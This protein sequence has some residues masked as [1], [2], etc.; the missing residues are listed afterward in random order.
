MAH[1]MATAVNRVCSI[2]A[3]LRSGDRPPK[4]SAGTLILPP[5]AALQVRCF[6]R[7]LRECKQT[8]G[9]AGAVKAAE[10]LGLLRPN[11]WLVLMAD[12]F[13]LVL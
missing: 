11:G 5:G 4:V 13:R 7:R 8:G 9:R 12:Q 6:T 1:L 3:A 10:G 2:S